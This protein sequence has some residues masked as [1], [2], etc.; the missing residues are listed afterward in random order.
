MKV[1]D[2]AS[3][4]WKRVDEILVA[5]PLTRNSRPEIDGWGC[6]L[7]AVVAKSSHTVC[8]HSTTVK[9]QDE[10]R[11]LIA[12]L[13]ELDVLKD[14]TMFSS[15]QLLRNASV[16]EHT[17]T[18]S[19]ISTYVTTGDFDGGRLVIAGDP[20]ATFRS[21]LEFD[22]AKPHWVEPWTGDRLSLVFYLHQKANALHHSDIQFLASLGFRFPAPSST[23]LRKTGQ[24]DV[25]LVELFVP[26]CEMFRAL[27]KERKISGH[28]L[29]DE[30]YDSM[31]CCRAIDPEAV[32]VDNNTDEVG[33]K[34]MGFLAQ[35]RDKLIVLCM[36]F[37]GDENAEEW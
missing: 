21:P 17:D 3:C 28:M 24:L 20:V 30:D 31:R 22:G 35:N 7:G 4:K 34:L 11:E 12:L 14:D 26:M 25:A 1:E 13:R 27:G 18:N 10:V 23:T 16:S 5:L 32:I 8:V 33:T 9:F 2:D 36:A 37:N 6:V 29:I 15:I 19:S